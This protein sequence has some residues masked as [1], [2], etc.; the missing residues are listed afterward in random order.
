MQNS[1]CKMQTEP[2]GRSPVPCAAF[3]H[4][5]RVVIVHPFCLLPFALHAK[6]FEWARQDSNLGPTDYEPAALTAELRA[7]NST[8][9]LLLVPT[10]NSQRGLGSWSLGRWELTR[11][12]SRYVRPSKKALSLRDLDG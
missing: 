2:A 8:P 12:H 7:P 3:A 9:N 6:H 5:P 11:E 4:L 1:K 10:S